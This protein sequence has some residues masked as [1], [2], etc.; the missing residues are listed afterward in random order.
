MSLSLIIVA[1]NEEK[2]I[3]AT[4]NSIYELVDEIVLIDAESTDGTVKVTQE[5]DKEKKLKVFH[6]DNPLNFIINKQRALE[7]ATKEWIIELD[8]DEIVTPELRKEIASVLGP[9]LDKTRSSIV[10]Y[11]IPRLNHF[12][13]KPLRKGGQYP[14]YTIR[15][16]K[17]DHAK[18]PVESIHDQVEIDG[19]PTT[20][21]NVI[22]NEK[23]SKLESPL[24]HYP[25]RSLVTFFRKWAQ[26]ASF[27]AE[28]K[29]ATRIQP[30]FF[31]F[32]NYCVWKPIHWFF[33]T[34]FRHRGYVD[35]FPGFAFSFFSALRFWVEY[36]RA[37]ELSSS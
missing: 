33:L 9:D 2:N 11:W 1:H 8:S 31:A 32:L 15:L 37:Y 17:K 34:Y 21:G 13:G 30:S 26:Y 36:M 5:L 19:L 14:D 18:F 24:M 16:Y 28:G 35:G 10:A 23:I 29:T 7:R 22:F 3:A 12:L 20:K 4:V 6:E 27:E 25:Y